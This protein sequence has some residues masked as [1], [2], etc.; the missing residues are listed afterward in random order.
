MQTST[1]AVQSTK[2]RLEFL[3]SL[4]GLAAVYVLIYHMVLLPQPSLGL[5]KWAEKFA[6]AGGTGVTL[7]FLVSAVSLYYTMPR[8]MQEPKPVTS[9]YL[10]RFFRIAPLFYVLIVVSLLRDMLVFGAVHSPAEIV[11]S[12]LFVFNLIPTWQEGFVWASWTIGVEMVFYALFPLIY[13]RVKS[14]SAGIALIF[15]LMMGW[16]V[17]QL[18]LDYI[19]MPADWRASIDKWLALR[20]FPTFAAGILVYQL[21]MP[22]L[23]GSADTNRSRDVGN[24]LV[25]AGIFAY[26]ALLQGW[27][28]G[29][30]GDAYYWQGLVFGFLL[31]GFALSP[32]RLVVNWVTGYLGRISYSIYLTHTTIIFFLSPVYGWIY[33]RSGSLTLGFILSLV[34]TMLVVIPVSDLCY[35]LFE[36]PGIKLGKYIASR[37]GLQR[38]S[39]PVGAI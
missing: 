12:A 35:R 17:V 28:P 13:A 38:Q 4:R 2:P 29:V 19:V 16:I 33:E 21:V 1:V 14:A 23:N 36:A 30:F 6:L 25:W 37:L 10:H 26:A 5:P 22:I 15:A 9:F 24:A 8:R 3:D 20:Y 7:F 31:S 11:S 27:L 39:A 18:A 34:L 32:W